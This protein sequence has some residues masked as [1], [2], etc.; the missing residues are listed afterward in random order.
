[1]TKP[2]R[3]GA[4]LTDL[5]EFTMLQSYFDCGMNDAATFEFFVRKL[6]AHRNFLMAAGLEQV[7][8]YLADLKLD[9]GEIEGLAS[10]GLFS[11]RFL[12]SL[13]SLRF[14]GSVRAMR[15]GTLFF[16]DEPILQITAPMREAQLIESR[17]MNLLHYESIVASK[18]ARAV[19]AAPGKTLV[20]FGLRRAHG[21]EAALLS[22]R[23]SYVAGFTGT[24][25]LLAGLRYGIPV[26]GTMA[27]S[28]VQAHAG[29][30]LAFEHFAR[31]FPRNAMLLIDT[32]DTEAAA[33]KVID[34]AKKLARDGIEV[35]G[36]RL[37]SGDLAQHA[38]R[39]RAIL[40]RAGLDR[41]TI[42]ASGNL[43]EYKLEELIGKGAPIDGFGVGT[44]MNTS[45]DAPYAD[46]AYKLTEYA[47]V[48]RRKR[49]EGKATWPGRKQVYRR[50]RDDGVIDGDSLALADEAHPGGA[51][52]EPFVIDGERVAPLPSLAG[53]RAHASKELGALP[54][55]LRDL[56]HAAEYPV[57]VTD[58]LIAL[59][60]RIDART[61]SEA[62]A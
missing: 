23:A 11:D 55:A 48:P 30:S 37:D 59:A 34:V 16:V 33:Y 47:G 49:S 3:D 43:D 50:Y 10:T 62:R 26:Y 22:A 40:D 54:A 1:M 7:L 31:S 18:A 57:A 19:L 58:A 39:V 21:A 35:K 32:Y 8:D 17:V 41:V 20:D 38:M 6:P 44:R 28:Y 56:T 2:V 36:V 5:Y 45:A 25:T 12:A 24:A 46:C 52:L 13:E 9:A 51:L 53:I 15:E 60:Q 27:H 42:F 61:A 4:L 14:T 29:E